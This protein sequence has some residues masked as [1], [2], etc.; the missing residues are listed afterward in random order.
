MQQV[1]I[2]NKTVT[3]SRCGQIKVKVLPF[4]HRQLFGNSNFRFVNK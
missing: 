2:K 4:A 3:L 1:K